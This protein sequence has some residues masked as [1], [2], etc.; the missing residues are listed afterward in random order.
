[1][2]R[3]FDIIFSATALILMSPLLILL[4][5]L[6]KVTGEGEIFFFQER[7]GRNGEVFQLFKFVTMLKNSPNIGT[8]TITTKDDPRVLPVGE[9]LRKTK[10]NEL[11][12]LLN[13]LIGDMSFIGPRPLTP[14][15]FG[16]YS[17]FIKN[18]IKKVR[19]GLSGIGSIIFRN[20]EEV[21]HGKDDPIK[22]YNKFV[23]PYKG[24]LE[25]WY[26]TNQSIFIYF[27]SIALTIFT[28]FWPQNG[29]I[30]RIFKDLPDPPEILTSKLK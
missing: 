25:V 21:L 28:V 7:I 17:D 26:V 30:W 13:I 9:F 6:L 23:A 5:I 29:F 8:K 16:M 22:F 18:N 2:A 4:L 24:E 3:V 14:E 15:T 1:M 19:P 20:E 10:I 11:P 27:V 12:Q